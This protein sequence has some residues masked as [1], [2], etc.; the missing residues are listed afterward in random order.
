M[1]YNSKDYNV[2]L[3]LRALKNAMDNVPRLNMQ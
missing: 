2:D 1:G 3:A